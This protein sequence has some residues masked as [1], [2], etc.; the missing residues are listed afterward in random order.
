MR[1]L[2]SALILGGLFATA[3]SA[4]AAGAVE[5]AFIAPASYTDGGNDLANAEENRNKIAAWLQQLGQQQLPSGEVLKIDVLDID[6]AGTLLPSR[7]ATGQLVRVA[8]GN[9]DYPRIKLRY[10]LLSGDKTLQ[11]GEETVADMN[12]L[13]HQ[14]EDRADDPLGHEKRMLAGWFKARFTEHRPAAG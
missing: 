9:A 4:H 3:M 2:R 6:I 14:P 8:R 1:T 11:R 5:V 7:R 10:T 13:R 12:Y